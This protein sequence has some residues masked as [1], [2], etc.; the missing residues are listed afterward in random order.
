M[1]G[2]YPVN[3]LT[4]KGRLSLPKWMVT[5][6]VLAVM[7]M[8]LALIVVLVIQAKLLVTASEIAEH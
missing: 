2:T 4:L 5:V 6:T 3:Y 8:I 7:V 1:G